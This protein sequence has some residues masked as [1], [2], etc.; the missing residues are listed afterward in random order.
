MIPRGYNRPFQRR[1]RVQPALPD[2]W[3]L[4]LETYVSDYTQFINGLLEQHP[5]WA[6]DQLVG[7]SLLWDK[8]VDFDELRRFAQ[9]RVTLRQEETAPKR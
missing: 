9:S 5:E 6:E 8:K 1:R 3:S 4:A 7:R 2:S